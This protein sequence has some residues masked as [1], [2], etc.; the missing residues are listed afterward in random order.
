MMRELEPDPQMLATIKSSIRSNFP[1]MLPEDEKF[2]LFSSAESGVFERREWSDG[3]KGFLGLPVEILLEEAS[4]LLNRCLI[5]RD[6]KMELEVKAL[7]FW[8]DQ[9][10]YDRQ[11]KVRRAQID[12]GE[13]KIQE[14]IARIEL[15]MQT[16]CLVHAERNVT[17]R[18]ES[19]R[20]RQPDTEPHDKR[21]KLAA[22]V[23]YLTAY[24]QFGE[25]EEAARQLA[26]TQLAAE[27]LSLLGDVEGSVIARTQHEHQRRIAESRATFESAHAPLRLEL[28]NEEA[29]MRRKRASLAVQPNVGLNYRQRL[30]EIQAIFDQDFISAY[31]RL[32]AV[33]RGLAS[34]YGIREPLS[35]VDQEPSLTH[36]LVWARRRIDDLACLLERE[37][38]FTQTVSVRA[39]ADDEAWRAFEG[40]GM[41]TFDLPASMFA[42]VVLVRL[43]GLQA[44]VQ[45]VHANKS[46]SIV[47]T[48]PPAAKA[49][50]AGGGSADIDQSSI[51]SLRLGNVGVRLPGRA[52]AR[53]DARLIA[54][55][56]P[57]G[58]WQLRLIDVPNVGGGSS[59]VDDVELD[60]RLACI[61]E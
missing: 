45:S 41:L 26:E 33:E 47:L 61:P 35:L 13:Y 11:E 10:L 59:A 4:A 50:Q 36:L 44:A 1:T 34:V 40:S 27:H 55:A 42:G 60:L 58:S 25:L 18:Q 8:L 21:V 51:P 39:L 54:N 31:E 24:R 23:A 52:E 15:E 9:E 38:V 14:D 16:S 46:W 28:F 29:N 37:V 53:V 6:A 57:I 12:A 22:K 56:S 17:H 5:A 43:R 7:E 3:V 48:V 32:L 2:P 20:A 19:E 30:I 49:L